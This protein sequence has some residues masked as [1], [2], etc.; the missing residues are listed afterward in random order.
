MFINFR[1]PYRQQLGYKPLRL[2]RP[3]KATQTVATPTRTATTISVAAPTAV[4]SAAA[5]DAEKG[6]SNKVEVPKKE[7]GAVSKQE[8]KVQGLA[9]AAE[10]CAEVVLVEKPK[11]VETLKPKAVEAQQ[12]DTKDQKPKIAEAPKPKVVEPQQPKVAEAQKPKSEDTAISTPSTSPSVAKEAAPT[13]SAPPTKTEN[14]KELPAAKSSQPSSDPARTAG[15]AT[16]KVLP[17]DE[18]PLVMLDSPESRSILDLIDGEIEATI[19]PELEDPSCKYS[20]QDFA[21]LVNYE[22]VGL[23][24]LLQ[25]MQS[26]WVERVKKQAPLGAVR[27]GQYVVCK[28]T[29]DEVAVFSRGI[30]V[31]KNPQGEIL[32]IDLGC[33]VFP[34]REIF[35]CRRPRQRAGHRQRFRVQV[36][37]GFTVQDPF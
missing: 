36:R 6:V 17:D 8:E 22:D 14:K 5:V 3:Q 33:N 7:S 13:P 16:A 18:D 28:K 1:T 30:V 9:N 32:S 25:D 21:C 26:A 35:P 20:A 37:P 11:T 24:F 31:A 34:T 10:K 23:D 12:Q 27:L 29:T 15:A 19:V 2:P 4:G